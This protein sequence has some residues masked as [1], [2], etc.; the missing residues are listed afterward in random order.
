MALSA[1]V[2]G[3]GAEAPKQPTEPAK[4]TQ[5]QLIAKL[6]PTLV[7]IEGKGGGG[8]GFVV[9]AR[10]GLVVTNAHVAV[11]LKSMKAQVG[12]DPATETPAQL[13]AASPCDD[14]A[15]V[16]LVNVPP[17][18]D[19]AAL[20]ESGG[21]QNGQHVTALGYP[22][23]FEEDEAIGGKGLAQQ[24]VNTEGSVSS[25][26]VAAAPDP[27][28]PRFPS[29]IQHQ[30]PV[31]PG[32]S[33][34]PLVDDFGRVIGINTLRNPEVQ[35]QFYAIS[36]DRAKPVVTE[37]LA[38]KSRGLVGWELSPLAAVD[39]GAEFAVDPDYADADLGRRV[40][41]LF[42]DN[43][44]DGM[45]VDK[46]ETGSPAYR[47]DLRWGDLISSIEGEPVRKMQDVCDIILAQPQGSKVRV[48][49][50]IMHSTAD[51]RDIGT[52]WSVE[53]KIK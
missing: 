21:V 53:M 23:S 26:N 49:G 51:R 35:G 40:A 33:G 11:A 17:S 9:D 37:L 28:L 20:G 41:R 2:A 1:L 48:N 25:A 34:G 19:Q 22:G 16:K 44:I 10:R 42:A 50:Y 45:Y 14:L 32:N 13:L 6:K 18:L 12:D 4:L 31:N 38:G 15:V 46:V 47:A 43:G 7:R 8:T 39:M 27:G 36:I 24:L 5:T 30:A 52:D 29:T 3:C